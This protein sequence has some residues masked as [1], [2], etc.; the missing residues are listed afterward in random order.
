MVVALAQFLRPDRPV[1]LPLVMLPGL[2]EHGEEHDLPI[3]STPVRYPR[4]NI[5]KQGSRMLRW[6]LIEAV[7]RNPADS[8]AGATKNAIIAR[9]GKEARNI[10]EVAAARRMLTLVYY[11]M[12]DGQFRA[13]TP[14]K[15]Q[16][17]QRAA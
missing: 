12:R 11:G 14:P 9:R 8:A 17:P 5:A 2:A 7:Q 10:A 4:C 1:D 15:A 16:P 13:L 6:A 3:R